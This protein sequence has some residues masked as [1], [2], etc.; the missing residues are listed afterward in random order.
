MVTCSISLIF[1]CI[2]N[3]NYIKTQNSGDCWAARATRRLRMNSKLISRC[4]FWKE[5][6]KRLS[7]C[8]LRL[9]NLVALGS[10][11]AAIIHERCNK[12]KINFYNNCIKYWS[13][14]P[15]RNVFRRAKKIVLHF[16]S[17]ICVQHF[18]LD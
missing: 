4:F 18:W 16:L 1:L 2:D 7:I 5:I 17:F 6:S 9:R 12:I 13:H 8:M 3:Y 10:P 11:G 15:K 14:L